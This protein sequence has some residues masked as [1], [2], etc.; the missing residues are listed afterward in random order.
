MAKKRQPYHDTQRVHDSLIE[1]MHGS[2]CYAIPDFQNNPTK[3]LWLKPF[4]QLSI[5]T[6]IIHYVMESYEKEG[7][8][9]YSISPEFIGPIITPCQSGDPIYAQYRHMSFLYERAHQRRYTHCTQDIIRGYFCRQNDI[10]GGRHKLNANV[11][12]DILPTTPAIGTDYPKAFG[13]AKAITL[14]H[15]LG[16][17]NNRFPKD[18]ICLISGGDGSIN[19]PSALSTFN[20]AK[21]SIELNEPLPLMFVISDNGVAISQRAHAPAESLLSH[22]G[23]RVFKA[24]AKNVLSVYTQADA[25]QQAVRT[26]QRP[27]ILVIKTYRLYGHSANRRNEQYSEQELNT[28]YNHPPLLYLMQLGEDIGAWS[29]EDCLQLYTKTF[30]QTQALAENTAQ[31]SPI[32]ST[33]LISLPLNDSAK[34]QS[35]LKLAAPK[36]PFTVR[37]VIN[38]VLEQTLEQCPHAI[39]F[40]QDI[41]PGHYGVGI[42]LRKRFPKQVYDFPIDEIALVGTGNGLIWNGILP[43]IEISYKAYFTEG[44]WQQVNEHMLQRFLSGRIPPT[45]M[46]IRMPA[47]GMVKGGP[48]HTENSLPERL[49]PQ[50]KTV[51]IGTPLSAHLCYR[52]AMDMALHQ[53]HCVIINEATHQYF[54][55]EKDY[56]D[57]CR[58]LFTDTEHIPFLFG[59]FIAYQHRAGESLKV[60]SQENFLAHAKNEDYQLITYG[61]GVKMALEAALRVGGNFTV[62]E[63]PFLTVTKALI[64]SIKQAQA[65]LIVDECRAPAC[66]GLDV[67]HQGAQHTSN[68][69]LIT[70]EDTFNPSGPAQK[71]CY[72]STEAIYQHI[73][74]IM[75]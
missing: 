50:V 64:A 37:R 47:L 36:S 38:S 52:A 40:G 33:K 74:S 73:K 17:A 4:L 21:R 67:F 55:T 42:G 22:W 43:I 26:Q 5:Q 57:G 8:A 10:N 65:T 30:E 7:L 2:A 75:T 15:Y 39:V 58:A 1:W 48:T 3:A 23:L 6:E 9:Y 24:D 27:A 19:H 69:S 46:I 49:I 44:G 29:R 35:T 61:N 45:G 18:A 12:L 56:P 32:L 14:A 59:D 51:C 41:S 31:E 53:H 71:Q 63:Y 68:I 72:L 13:T 62:I 66:P 16:Y 28:L 34:R 11:D 54:L 70:S 60:V 20:M 25:C